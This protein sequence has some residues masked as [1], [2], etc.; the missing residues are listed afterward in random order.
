M[1]TPKC[2][3]I[4]P[5]A[6]H[7]YLKRSAQGGRLQEAVLQTKLQSCFGALQNEQWQIRVYH[8]LLLA[9]FV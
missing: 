4:L 6:K 2:E 7:T 5:E 9:A 3:G 8:A 1:Y